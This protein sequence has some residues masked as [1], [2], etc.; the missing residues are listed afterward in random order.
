MIKG[1]DDGLKALNITSKAAS[2]ASN[3]LSVVSNRMSFF[4]RISNFT[5]N[6][7]SHEL[8]RLSIVLK[9]TSEALKSLSKMTK[10][11][12]FVSKVMSD[13]VKNEALIVS[14]EWR[15]KIEDR[16]GWL[17][18]VFFM[19]LLARLVHIKSVYRCSNSFTCVIS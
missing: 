7:M 8:K 19:S 2:F 13:E 16:S 3:R 14:C 4:V 6:R 1:V 12:I 17:L 15:Q 10:A 18:S 9:S 5:S 11:E